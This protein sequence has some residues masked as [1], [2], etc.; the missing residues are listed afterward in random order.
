M[1]QEDELTGIEYM[2][3][4]T[5][6]THLID[7]DTLIIGAGRFPELAFVPVQDV[8]ESQ[9]DGDGVDENSGSLVWEGVELQKKP[10]SNREKGLLSSQDVISEYTSA[11]AAINGGRKAATLMHHMIY[12]IELPNPERMIAEKSLVQ[13][14]HSLEQVVPS[15]RNILEI[16][17]SA[18]KER[19]D[20]FSMGFSAITAEEEANRCLRCGLVCYEK[21]D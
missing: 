3:L 18:R 4:D 8:A 20:R 9:D 12:N 6:T 19:G 16:A 7:T 17:T 15:P 5:G 1:G 10:E 21:K 2:D 13:D 11:V 14:I